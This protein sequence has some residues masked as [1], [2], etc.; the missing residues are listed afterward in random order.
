MRYPCY[1]STSWGFILSGSYLLSEGLNK[2]INSSLLEKLRDLG[3]ERY[4]AKGTFLL[5]QGDHSNHF[6]MFR[7]GMAKA[8]YET[9]DGREFIKSFIRENEC[10]ASLQ[11][12]IAGNPSPFNLMTVENS[13]LLEIRGDRLMEVIKEDAG[14]SSALSSLLIQVAMKKELREYELLC[15]SAEQRYLLLCEREPELIRRLSQND[16]AR[17]LGITPVSL[18]R[19]RSRTQSRYPTSGTPSSLSH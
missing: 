8:Y 19:I 16:V 7:Q 2:V 12:I 10:I 9:L 5:R 6:F 13:H 1:Y 11:V 18:S 3:T 15:L 17:Y 14:F 4:A